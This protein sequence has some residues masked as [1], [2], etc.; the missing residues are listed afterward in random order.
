M[1]NRIHPA[2]GVNR[3]AQRGAVIEI[4]AVVPLTVPA[5]IF[6]IEAQP[7]RLFYAVIGKGG[8]IMGAGDFR[9]GRERIIEKKPQPHA[10]APAV[11]ADQIH[12]VVPVTGADK[13]E[14]VLAEFKAGGAG[15]RA[16]YGAGC[17][18]VPFATQKRVKA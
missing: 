7:C 17:E 3:R 14:T 13:R 5:V 1:H 4:G 12:P 9:E 2:F 18:G 15:A 6:D 11:L 8:V 10:F 16:R